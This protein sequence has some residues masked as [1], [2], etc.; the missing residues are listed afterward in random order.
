MFLGD[1]KHLW[2]DAPQNGAQD[3][4][5]CWLSPYSGLVWNTELSQSYAAPQ[6]RAQDE[7]MCWLS[8]Y[9]G[10]VWNTELSQSY[11]TPSLS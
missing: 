2:D 6:N 1:F 9:S 11:A 5:M 10:L 3:E 7:D 4:D 8:P